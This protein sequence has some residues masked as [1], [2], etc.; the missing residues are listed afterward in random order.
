MEGVLFVESRDGE[1]WFA[2]KKTL[3][4]FHLFLLFSYSMESDRFDSQCLY[5]LCDLGR[6]SLTFQCLSLPPMNKG[7]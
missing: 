4:H 7:L 1:E 5:L 2:V 3:T 6:S